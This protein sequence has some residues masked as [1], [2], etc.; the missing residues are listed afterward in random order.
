MSNTDHVFDPEALNEEALEFARAPE[1]DLEISLRPQSFREF[2]GQARVQDNLGVALQ[3][4]RARNE[5][6]DHVLLSGPPGLGKTSLA[7]ILAKELNTQLHATS[8]PALERPRDLVGILTQLKRCD[9]LF[10]DEVHRVPAPVEEFLYTA[11]EDFTVEVTLDQGPHARILPLALQPF[12]L[13]GATTREGL[14]TAPFRGRFG[15]AE[16]LD[17][18]PVSD[19]E[20]IVRRSAAILSVKIDGHAARLIAERSRGTPRI[21]NR[22]LRRVRDLAQVLQAETVDERLANEALQRMGVDENGLEELDRRILRVLVSNAPAPVGIKTIAAAVG[23]AEDTIEE[24]FEPHLLR[25]G[26]LQKTARGRVVTA[27]GCTAVGIDA[28]SVPGA[29]GTLFSGL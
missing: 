24:V 20:Q 21:A 3:A 4:A 9:V 8:G 14:L 27:E 18:Y 5:P 25:S 26:F 17:P 10:I 19:L 6:L 7:R 13:I 1:R 12:T 22:F 28:K 2:V 23:E 15:I 29:S 11:M 16:R